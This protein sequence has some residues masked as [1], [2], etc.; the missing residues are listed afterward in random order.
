[1]KRLMFFAITAVLLAAQVNDQYLEYTNKLVNYQI[2]LNNVGQIVPPFE[3]PR[4]DVVFKNREKKV[5]RKVIK[6]ELVSIFNGRAFVILKEYLGSQLVNIRKRWVKPGD[7]ID[8][9]VVGSIKE[10]SIVIKCQKR[11][12][13]KSLN[14][15]IPFFK[16]QK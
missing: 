16:E 6:V 13:V 8:K 5:I 7:K 4:N 11:R 15:K 10:D 1:M 3:L 2:K 12:I 9:C 14:K